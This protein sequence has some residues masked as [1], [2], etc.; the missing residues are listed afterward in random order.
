MCSILLR[1]CRTYH[2]LLSIGLDLG[3]RPLPVG[4]SII[5][6]QVSHLRYS[7]YRYNERQLI[8]ITVVRRVRPRAEMPNRA[9]AAG[10]DYRW[11]VCCKKKKTYIQ[12]TP[13]PMDKKKRKKKGGKKKRKDAEYGYRTRE[14]RLHSLMVTPYAT[15]AWIGK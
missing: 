4:L 13:P 8:D 9:P 3:I 2:V 5:L 12:R 11:V 15:A 10:G 7:S 14:L 1:L 6:N